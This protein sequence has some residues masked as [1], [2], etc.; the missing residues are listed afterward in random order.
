MA[1]VGIVDA[2]LGNPRSVL[3]MLE[4][5]EVDAFLAAESHQ[6]DDGTHLILPGVGHFDD[7]VKK[8]DRVGMVEPILQLVQSGRPLLGICL[9]MQLLGQGSEEGEAPGLGLMPWT[10]K[11]LPAGAG[12]RVPHMG[13]SEVDSDASQL[14]ANGDERFYFVHSYYVDA[15][16]PHV[17]ASCDYGVRIAATVES[18]NVFGVQFHPEKSHRY[19]MALLERFSRLTA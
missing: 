3:R 16:E 7:A 19:G 4:H 12:Y 13:W 18:Q 8:L 6:F 1:R 17:T 5:I 14:H 15:G 9:G 11:A 2:G 10:C